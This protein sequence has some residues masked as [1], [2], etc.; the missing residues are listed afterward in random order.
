M[1][2]LLLSVLFFGWMISVKAQHLTNRQVYDFQPGDEIQSETYWCLSPTI[3]ITQSDSIISKRISTNNDTFYY[4]IRRLSVQYIASVPPNMSH[5]TNTKGQIQL[6]YTNLDSAVQK[7]SFSGGGFGY[8]YSN[9]PAEV[10]TIFNDPQV[11]NKQSETMTDS[12]LWS[13]GFT[14]IYYAGLGDPFFLAG[15]EVWHCGN[16]RSLLFYKKGNDSCGTR[17]DFSIYDFSGVNNIEFENSISIF[18]NPTS[19]SL[20]IKKST[21]ENLQFHLYNLIGQNVMNEN[22]KN[23]TTQIE[24]NGL[25]A[26]TYLFSITNQEGKIVQTGKVIFE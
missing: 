18:P 15:A 20:T 26:S 1:K 9:Q 2:K 21:N 3:T 13:Y 5:Y 11:C 10:D 12:S 24:R 8:N 14:T 4:T 6:I 22:L 19:S 16:H 7:L 25:P 17:I 23:E